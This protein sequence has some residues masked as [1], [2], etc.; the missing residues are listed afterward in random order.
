M[1]D[2][3]LSAGYGWEYNSV[4]TKKFDDNFMALAKFAWFNSEGDVF[5]GKAPL[6]DATRFSVEL[7][8]TF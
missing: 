3:E 2:N 6:P 7:N 4:L 8:Y 1:G 5:A